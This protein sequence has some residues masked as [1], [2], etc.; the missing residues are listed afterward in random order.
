MTLFS[1]LYT[2]RLDR[3]LGTDDSTVLGDVPPGI[4]AADVPYGRLRYIESSSKL[5]LRYARGFKCSQFSDLLWRQLGQ[6]VSL[7]VVRL[8]SLMAFLVGVVRV[9]AC[10][11][12]KQMRRIAAGRVIADVADV[13]TARD[14]LAACEYPRDAMRSDVAAAATE[15]AEESVSVRRDGA[16]PRPAGIG[17]AALDAFMEAP[18]GAFGQMMWA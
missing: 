3:E 9:V 5:A 10:C 8:S 15:D 18:K 11:S 4:A 7:S 14:G 6:T 16:S 13:I 1:S 17:I 2:G 12:E